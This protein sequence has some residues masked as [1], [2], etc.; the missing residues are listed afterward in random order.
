MVK[1][2]QEYLHDGLKTPD[3]VKD[4][5]KEQ[6]ASWDDLA[7]FIEDWCELE[8]RQENPEAYRTRI[9]ATDLHETF[10]IWYARYKDKRFSISGK[11]FSEMLNKKDIPAKRSN[12]IQRLGITLKTD[13]WG[14]LE[15][16]R[17]FKPST[18]FRDNND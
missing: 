8:P 16:A 13:A 3:K 2:A 10:C 11:K 7:Q 18:S 1:G 9:S 12:G 6:R 14:E 4:W 17:A 5:T 15:K